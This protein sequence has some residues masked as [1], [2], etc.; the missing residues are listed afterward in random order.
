MQKYA[1][2]KEN[3]SFLTD[4]EKKICERNKQMV[5]RYKQLVAENPNVTKNRIFAKIAEEFDL[6][7][8]G[9]RTIIKNIINHDNRRTEGNA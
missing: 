6:S 8:N 4:K 3:Y 7:T 2:M 9:T 1:N 5:A